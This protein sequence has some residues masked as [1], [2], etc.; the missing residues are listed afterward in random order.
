MSASLEANGNKFVDQW[1]GLVLE[2]GRF[3]K[4]YGQLVRFEDMTASDYL[5]SDSLD[6]GY[7]SGPDDE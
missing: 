3:K 5:E 1:L 6:F 4:P 7:M 2:G